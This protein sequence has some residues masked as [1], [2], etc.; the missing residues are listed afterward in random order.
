MKLNEQNNYT[1]LIP[2]IFLSTLLLGLKHFTD[3]R[4]SP[5]PAAAKKDLTAVADRI[6]SETSFSLKDKNSGKL[7]N[8]AADAPADADLVIDSRYNDWRYWNGLINIAMIRLGKVLNDS[9]YINYALKNIAFDF[10]NYKYFEK[11]YKGEDK[12]SYPY[13]QLFTMADLDDYGSMGAGVIEVYKLDKKD[14]YKNYIDKAADHILNFQHRFPDGSFIR[15][16]PK[17]WTL[18]A[19]DL[20]MSIS[21]LSRMGELSGDSKYF[22][23]A[24][25]QVINYNNHLFDKEKGLMYH[26]WYSGTDKHGVAFWGRANGWALLAQIDL[27]ERVPDNYSK[28]DTL[29]ALF[30]RHI[31][32]IIKYQDND[33]LWHQ[34][35]D[36][37]D[38]YEE[39]SCSAM[40]TYSIARAVN[41]G[42]LDR[43]YSAYAVKGWEGLAS[44]IRPDGQIEGV[45]TGTVVSDNLN[46]YYMRPAPLNDVHG[47]GVVLLA[48]CEI[49]N[50]KK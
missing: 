12:W 33:G 22:D 19:D 8:S 17:R 29:L 9:S 1:V 41:R 49:L 50:L 2:V 24:S 18:W 21:F 26:N 36:K 3:A 20:Y 4:T 5:F 46:D 48:G 13:G 7:Y 23:L 43:S 38:S 6:I 30:K 32:G 44:K 34:L 15:S 11:R 28:R 25:M 45:C 39:T 35:I 37:E 16:F 10:D 42:I 14:A 31:D 27:L 40:F 47:I